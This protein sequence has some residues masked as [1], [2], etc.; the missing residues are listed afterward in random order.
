MHFTSPGWLSLI[1]L[2]ALLLVWSVLTRS[3]RV[4]VVSSERLWHGIP[5]GPS[6]SAFRLRPKWSSA[7]FLAIAILAG[8]GIAAGAPWLG[9]ARPD[10]ALA[11]LLDTSPSMAAASAEP[12]KTTSRRP[13]EREPRRIDD[14]AR[15]AASVLAGAAA[16]PLRILVLA[17]HDV[18][19]VSGS[20]GE[21]GWYETALSGL[22]P[23][24]DPGSFEDLV[25]TAREVI[26]SRGGGR[27]ILISD[28][29]G[30]PRMLG[31]TDARRQEEGALVH[32]EAVGVGTP[33][34]NV[35]I[36]GLALTTPTGT[37]R[38]VETVTSV[39][40]YSSRPAEA[41]LTVRN[42][43]ASVPGETILIPPGRTWLSRLEADAREEGWVEARV[44]PGGGLD[45]DDV[46]RMMSR[47]RRLT[48]APG[49]MAPP[50]IAAA[51]EALALPAPAADGAPPAVLFL[52]HSPERLP[53]RWIVLSSNRP[54]AT[55][56]SAA[57]VALD[58]LPQAPEFLRRT[59]PIFVPMASLPP[60]VA[61]PGTIPVALAAGRPAVALMLGPPFRGIWCGVPF[62]AGGSASN[63]PLRLDAML[64]WL[65]GSEIDD[66]FQRAEALDA[67][68]RPDLP[69]HMKPAMPGGRAA[70]VPVSLRGAVSSIVLGLV[71]LEGCRRWLAL[72]GH[73]AP[74][75]DATLGVRATA[76]STGWTAGHRL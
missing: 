48:L 32:F 76:H 4:H 8:L 66:G 71:V 72:R 75:R 57:R 27:V 55:A 15:E 26:S 22:E 19:V 46:V 37:R 62:E 3:S 73:E 42:G 2:A 65:D 31:S 25:E 61:P 67:D 44:T 11:V 7:L 53:P 14:A 24:S 70:S 56:K 40:N 21:S 1:S 34:D 17:G 51:I 49:A 30:A 43:G 63:I 10:D 9:G 36:T 18:H 60:S 54:R 68:L 52:E 74:I 20:S 29:C 23:S 16:T 38:T 41:T 58:L 50:E 69:T 39:R 12:G 64:Q 5:I 59:G 35:A 45:Q 13:P 6:P 33:S 28:F 47:P